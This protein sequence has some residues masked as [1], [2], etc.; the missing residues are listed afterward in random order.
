MK[1]A[2]VIGQSASVTMTTVFDHPHTAP[3]LSPKSRLVIDTASSTAPGMS[4]RTPFCRSV[5]G[6]IARATTKP[7]RQSG[8]WAAKTQRHPNA[9][10]TGAP[11]TTPSTG[12]PALTND[13]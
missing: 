3:R 2:I 11:T 12:A 9:S 10:T 6:R 1:A 7:M 5:S 13:Q 8:T 4:K